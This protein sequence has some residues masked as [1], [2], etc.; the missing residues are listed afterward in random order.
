[1]ASAVARGEADVGLG[2]EKTAMQVR[3]IDFVPL[4]KERYEL[5]MKKEDM[6]K[7]YFQAVLE[8]LQS[9]EF[10]RNFRVWVIMI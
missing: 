1:M 4:Q 6:N 8:I 9:P 10:K 3:E 2:N 7:P 5:V